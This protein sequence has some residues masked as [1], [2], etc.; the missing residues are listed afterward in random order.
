M[1][2]LPLEG[3]VTLRQEQHEH[4]EEPDPVE[5][6]QRHCVVSLR[7]ETFL[8]GEYPRQSAVTVFPA[9]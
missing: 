3:I 5:I 9:I 7:A 4:A 1:Y 8:R 2:S 6:S